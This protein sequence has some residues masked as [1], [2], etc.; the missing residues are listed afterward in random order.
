METIW[1][2]SKIQEILPQRYPFLFIDKVIDINKKKKKVTCL[3]EV[4]I[5]D[6]FFQ[7]HFP[8]KPVMPGVII[9]E[10]MAQASIV[11]YAVLKPHIAEK[12]P[13]YYLGKVQAKFKKPVIP[14][15]QL[16]LEVQ[17][18]KVLDSSGIVKAY[19][20]VGSDI[21]AEAQ[22]VFGVKINGKK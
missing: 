9:I 2:I 22:I 15:D 4:S 3:K 5:N 19:A 10:A 16:I 17:G 6:S 20:K 12:K 21:V 7:G 11:L 14:G 1:D 13:D 18:E 8:N